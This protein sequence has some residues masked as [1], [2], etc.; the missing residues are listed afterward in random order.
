MTEQNNV[1][2]NKPLC[3]GS[4][5]QNTIEKGYTNRI[6][7][8]CRVFVDCCNHI[9][10]GNGYYI[11]KGRRKLRQVDDYDKKKVKFSDKLDEHLIQI[12]L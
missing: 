8:R 9:L 6:C 5:S 12:S 7:M 4:K 11:K 1:I 3:F 2:L 10:N